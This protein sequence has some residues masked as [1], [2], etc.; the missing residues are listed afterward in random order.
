MKPTDEQIK[1]FWEWCGF[2]MDNYESTYL[3]TRYT[4]PGKSVYIHTKPKLDLTNLF[5]YAVPKLPYVLLESCQAGY[6]A[7][8]SADMKFNPEVLDKDPALALFWA[9]Y[10]VMKEV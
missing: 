8:V 7:S 3:A 2:K 10:E 5:T 1:E 9:I 6:R 4:Y